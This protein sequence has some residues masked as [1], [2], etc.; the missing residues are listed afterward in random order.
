M[1]ETIKYATVLA[2]PD[3]NKALVLTH[4]PFE[5]PALLADALTE[6]GFEM[7]AIRVWEEREFPDTGAFDLLVVMGGPM[8][9]NDEI[10][11]PWLRREKAYIKEAIASG[12]KVLGICLGAQLIAS[13]LGKPVYPNKHKE[14]GWFPVSALSPG[15]E[16]GLPDGF[17]TFH[18]HGETFDL[19]EG[20][21]RIAFSAGC[22]NQAFIL[23]PNVL[24]CQFHPEASAESV[25]AL[26]EACADELVSSE[27][28]QTAA[29]ILNPAKD[30]YRTNADTLKVL[31]DRLIDY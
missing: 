28:V 8:S 31:L 24:A 2:M 9:V 1:R 3:Q 14:V 10:A 30:I 27:Y 17:L 26:T 11:H 12:K 23:G 5:G 6:R 25:R 4:V 21:E 19:P 22:E 15:K 18:W 16:I 20:A 29:Q 13:A 7:N